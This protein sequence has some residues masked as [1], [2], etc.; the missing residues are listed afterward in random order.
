MLKLEYCFCADHR[1]TLWAKQV[2]S[3][4][5]GDGKDDSRNTCKS[6]EKWP[7]YTVD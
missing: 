7:F 1:N 4:D 6:H 5:K 2:N 3:N